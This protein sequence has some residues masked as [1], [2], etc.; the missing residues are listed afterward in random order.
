MKSEIPYTICHGSANRFVLVDAVSEAAALEG[1]D[2]AAFAR[3]ACEQLW[4]HRLDGLL[5]LEKHEGGYAMRML[6]TDGSQAEMCGNGIRCVARLTDERYLHQSEFVLFSGRG[7]YPI[8]REE[9]IFDSLATY[10]VDIAIRTLG[11]EFPRGGERF[12]NR[13]IKALHPEL[14]FSYLNLGNPHLVAVVEEVDFNLLEELGRK[15][16]TLKEWFPHGINLSLLRSDGPRE[17]FVATWERGVGLTNSCGT[18]MTASST[19]AVLLGLSPA[20]EELKV[21]NRGGMVRCN[22]HIEGEQITTRLVGNATF[23]AEGRLRWEAG[24]LYPIEQHLLTEEISNYDL[25]IA[26]LGREG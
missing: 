9:P 19:V 18:A 25:F 20:D 17:L 26:E 24:R 13:P 7:R 3:A 15:I 8:R 1:V 21:R 4:S 14:R 5:L 6:N 16:P 10:G 23:E 11:E 2:R 22:C 12:L